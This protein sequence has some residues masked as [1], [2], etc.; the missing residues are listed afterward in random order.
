MGFEVPQIE[1]ISEPEKVNARVEKAPSL[2][3]VR[4]E[5]Q[6]ELIARSIARTPDPV[7]EKFPIEWIEKNAAKA[8][9]L[10]EE[11]KSEYPDLQTRWV[12]EPES[13]ISFMEGGLYPAEETKKAA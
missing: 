6:M 4:N 1:N 10:F 11:L 13:L 12:T 9:E 7:F 3:S 2:L 8:G 5:L